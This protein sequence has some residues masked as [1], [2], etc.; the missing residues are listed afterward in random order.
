MIAPFQRSLGVHQYVRDVLDIAHL[1]LAAAN[2][3]QRIVGRRLRIGRIEQQYAA[4]SRAKARR[5]SPVLTLDVVHD[6]AAGPGQKRRHH[7]A[8]A[9]AG[10]CRC[11]AQHVLRSIMAQIVMFEPSEHDAIMRGE[12]GG[13]NL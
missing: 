7:E 13:T 6:A 4:M 2:L 11:K 5:Q 10:S 9:L 1:P 8:D 12:T 3:K